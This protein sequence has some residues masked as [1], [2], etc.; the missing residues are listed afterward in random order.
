MRKCL[1]MMALAGTAMGGAGVAGSSGSVDVPSPAAAA[2]VGAPER[3]RSVI[4][5]LC[6]G[7]GPG[8]ISTVSELTRAQRGPLVME[9][10]P[11]TG[12]VRTASLTSAVTDSAAGATAYA[13][14]QKCENSAVN[15]YPDG[16]QHRTLA[17]MA[18]DRG[19]ATALLT[20]TDLTDATPASFIA[21]AP[22]RSMH[23]PIFDQMVASGVDLLVGGLRT[24]SL[25]TDGKPQG[26]TKETPV[27][28]SETLRRRANQAGRLV[29]NSLDA[30]PPSVSDGTR[31]LVAAPERPPH[32]DAFGPL[33]GETLRA[34]LEMLSTDPDGFFVLAEVE[35]TDNAGHAADT[36]RAITAVLEGDETLRVALEFQKRHPDTLIVLTA[37]HDTGSL[38]LDNQGRYATPENAVMWVSKNH[39]ANRV[40]VFASG[41]GAHRFTGTHENTAI[42]GIIRD[43][44]RFE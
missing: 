25:Q 5:I 24:A 2:D 12:L 43:L 23:G 28:L 7:M 4:F 33:M 30:L 36:E 14:G 32:D 42:F 44:M 20:T 35:E 3:P 10:M 8:M 13:T 29:I 31:V 16:S 9:T 39:T 37:D 34:A 27:P 1:W 22:K 15:W 17:E 6:D 18:E 38:S 21:R 26:L 40:V 41:P 19:M 11:V